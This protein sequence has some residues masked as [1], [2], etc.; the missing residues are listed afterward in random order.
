MDDPTHWYTGALT[1]G[2]YAVL[3]GGEAAGKWLLAF[4]VTTREQARKDI[5]ATVASAVD[6]AT[7]AFKHVLDDVREELKQVREEAESK[8]SSL[9][10][11]V[12]ELKDERHQCAEENAA[13]R[14]EVRQLK[15]ENAELRER[16]AGLEA[17]RG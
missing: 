17:A 9:K 3:R 11:E 12:E 2:L 5:D 14:E 6:A 7:S 4:I 10:A 13:L 16:V 15:A 1:F 8:V